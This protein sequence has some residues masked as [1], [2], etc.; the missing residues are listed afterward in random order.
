MISYEYDEQMEYKG[1][2]VCQLDPLESKKAGKE[3]YLLP[4]NCTFEKPPQEKEGYKI[5]WNGKKWD[6][7]E[8]PTNQNQERIDELKS[9]L[10]AADY[11]GQKYI[12]G[13]YSDDEWNEKKAQRK[14]WREEIRRLEG[15]N[16]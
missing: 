11:W 16:A 10:A 7:V 14:V 15:D 4:A 3:V 5:V 12:D 6:Y 1:E 8:I 2:K 13:E 9:L